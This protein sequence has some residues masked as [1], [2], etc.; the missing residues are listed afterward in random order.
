MIGATLAITCCGY[1]LAWRRRGPAF[2]SQPGHGILINVAILILI[3]LGLSLIWQMFLGNSTA[4]V[5]TPS[6]VTWVLQAGFF[7]QQLLAIGLSL[8]LAWW[9]RPAR[10]WQA[11]FLFGALGASRYLLDGVFRQALAL[12]DDLAVFGPFLASGI[13]LI[14][15]SYPA[16]IPSVALVVAVLLDRR[17][18]LPRH[19]SHWAGVVT[20]LSTLPGEIVVVLINQ[21]ILPQPLVIE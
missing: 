7:V 8:W 13:R 10:R 4:N 17:D 5:A 20:F 18:R 6:A 14:L 3:S 21:G 11:F 1:G 19:W 16:L 12:V 2:P 15:G 9:V